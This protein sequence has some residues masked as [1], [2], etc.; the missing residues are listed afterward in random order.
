[1]KQLAAIC[2]T[3]CSRGESLAQQLPNEFCMVKI[4][5]EIQS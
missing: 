3:I 5:C 4:E 1:M 2:L